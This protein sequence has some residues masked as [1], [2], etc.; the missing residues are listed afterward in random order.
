MSENP[1]QNQQK[2]LIVED[3]FFIRELYQRQL[4]KE[5]YLVEAAVDGAEGL[6][7][8]NDFRP[9]LILLDIM[10]PKL[11]GLDLLRTIKTKPETKD[12]PV[13]LLT[14]LGQESVIKE[15]FTLGAEGYLIKSA[16]TPSQIIEEVKNFLAKR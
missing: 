13:I 8:A 5:G 3:D 7:K 15:G 10:L 4:L 11:N 9:H 12:I 2:I 16:Y 14:N 6:V 1:P